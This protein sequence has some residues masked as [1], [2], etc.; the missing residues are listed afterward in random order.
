MA[1]A[2]ILAFDAST[3]RTAIVL[4][5]IDG[6][7]D[8]IVVAHEAEDRPN[9]TSGTLAPRIEE[10]L[11]EAG[12]R[13]NELAAVACGRG[14]GTFTGTRVAL[15]TAMGLALGIGGPALAVSTLAAVA[16]SVDAPDVL[17]L[18]DAR[19]DEVYA[20]VF[21]HG[22]LVGDERCA[23]LDRVLEELRETRPVVVGPGVE[24]YRAALVER[25]L[26]LHPMPGPTASGLWRASALAWRD[27]GAIDPAAL[28]AVYLRESYAEMGVNAPKRAFM[29]SPFV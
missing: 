19:R 26:A 14:P 16:C 5:R 20:G 22:R 7:G 6:A 8:A 4:G 15:A 11:R 2:L 27:G 25:G 28:R 23:A 18:L 12:V 13:A 9:Q 17:A 1:G 21:A 29:K 3:P 10:L 24:P